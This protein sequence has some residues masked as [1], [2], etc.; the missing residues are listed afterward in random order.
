MLFKT[1]EDA[2]AFAKNINKRYPQYNISAYEVGKEKHAIASYILDRLSVDDYIEANT[3]FG[4]CLI[5]KNNKYASRALTEGAKE[6]SIGDAVNIME[7]CIEEFNDK[8]F[9]VVSDENFRFSF[10]PF[11]A[12]TS[13]QGT[14]SFGYDQD[15]GH[16]VCK[17]SFNKNLLREGLEDIFINTIWHELCHYA[18]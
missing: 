17:I 7:R 5:N 6:M 3:E 2:N 14:T 10:E 16:F 18:V 9:P 13:R 1:L 15:E 11:Y 12:A 4:K 8:I